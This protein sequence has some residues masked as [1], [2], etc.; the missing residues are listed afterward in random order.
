MHLVASRCILSRRA[1]NG[2]KSGAE[3]ACLSTQ[4]PSISKHCI[5]S[6]EDKI[7]YCIY[8]SDYD[9]VRTKTHTA[10]VGCVKVLGI[11]RYA[12]PLILLDSP[13]ALG[14]AGSQL[15]RYGLCA[16]GSGGTIPS[17]PQ[18]ETS[19][20]PLRDDPHEN[21]LSHFASAVLLRFERPWS[22]LEDMRVLGSL[23]LRVHVSR[24]LPP[25][26]EAAISRGPL[27]PDPARARERL[28]G[29]M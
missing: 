21:R 6:S 25:K 29:P 19:R 10:G 22:P 20:M 2:S 23:G 9:R 24:I 26:M 8:Y 12:G 28:P 1:L 16:R 17:L 5:I 27:K 7:H 13:E 14:V 18:D 3:R 11:R 4:I 15:T